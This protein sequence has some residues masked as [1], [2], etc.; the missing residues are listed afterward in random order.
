MHCLFKTPYIQKIWY[1]KKRCSR[2]FQKFEQ[3][4]W[5]YLQRNSFRFI[6]RNFI[7]KELISRYFSRIL[8]I[9]EG[10]HLFLKQFLMVAMEVI[11]LQYVKK[12]IYRHLQIYVRS[13]HQK[14]LCKNKYFGKRC[15]LAVLDRW[16]NVMGT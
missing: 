8:S 7:K 14:D 5:K 4:P 3:N 12:L 9:R 11:F 2:I 1:F 15:I 6:A 13:G 16:W 10:T